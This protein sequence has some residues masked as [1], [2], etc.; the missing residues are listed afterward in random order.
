MIT[1]VVLI[2]TKRGKTNEVGEELAG[3]EGILEVYSVSGRYDLVALIKLTGNDDFADLM[4]NKIS[5]VKGI[6]NT[7]SMV[8]FRKISGQDIAFI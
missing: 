1:A 7:E 6:K 2:N 3:M 5:R 8:A 4:T